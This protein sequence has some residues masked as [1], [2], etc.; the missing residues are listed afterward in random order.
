MQALNPSSVLLATHRVLVRLAV[1]SAQQELLQQ[2]I[3]IY[4]ISHLINGL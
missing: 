4:L 1:H 2:Q 3:K